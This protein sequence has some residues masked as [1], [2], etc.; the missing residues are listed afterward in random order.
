MVYKQMKP[1]S[2]VIG[3]GLAHRPLGKEFV[4][5]DHEIYWKKGD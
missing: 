1:D 3:D 2:Y 4:K 5:I